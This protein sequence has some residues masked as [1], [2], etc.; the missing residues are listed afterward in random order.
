MAEDEAA[1]VRPEAEAEQKA[2]PFSLPEVLGSREMFD[3]L[4]WLEDHYSAAAPQILQI[5]EKSFVC[6]GV[7]HLTPEI[8]LFA[9]PTQCLPNYAVDSTRTVGATRIHGNGWT[10]TVGAVNIDFDP[11]PDTE[12]ELVMRDQTKQLD[13]QLTEVL[14]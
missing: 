12:I 7:C 4:E 14:F 10:Y 6:Y 8:G 2:D 3:R 1:D 9:V 13:W 11:I 5:G